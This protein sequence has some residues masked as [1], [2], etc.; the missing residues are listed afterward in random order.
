MSKE[1]LIEQLKD[2]S[3]REI[4]Q[5]SEFHGAMCY[6]PA[7]P[8]ELM[9]LSGECGSCG[10]CIKKS[11]YHLMDPEKNND[12]VEQIKALGYDAK[13]E[14]LCP[15]CAAQVGIKIEGYNYKDSKQTLFSSLVK[16]LT[17]CH[18]ILYV[19]YFKAKGQEEYHIAESDIIDG[20][21]AV[22]AFL[23]DEPTYT[24]PHHAIRQIKYDLDRIKRLTGISVE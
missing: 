23:K 9:T 16:K 3:E 7:P 12:V 21:K 6:S 19:F 17:P 13:V 24:G 15:D 18:P 14:F 2:L 22:L 4:P 5:D 20:Y 10:R 8:P 1:E 11:G